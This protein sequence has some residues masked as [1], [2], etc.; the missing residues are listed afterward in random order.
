[1]K[2]RDFLA[3]SVALASAP[4]I[5]PARA[6]NDRIVMACWGGGT[7][8]MWRD[9]FGKPFTAASNIPVTVAE[10]A[11][12]A[13]AIAAAQG[14]PQHNVI[15]AASFQGA[16]LAR[17]GLIE[18]FDPAEL[19][20][21]KH[22]PEQYWIRNSA[23]KI[24]GMPVYFIYYG[25]AYSTARC[26]ASDFESWKSL[27]D[28]RWKGQL[29][30]TRPVFLAPYDLTICSKVMGGTEVNIQPGIPLLRDIA[31]N[32][33]TAYTSMAQLQQQLA[34]GEV[35]AAPFYSSQVQLL[36]RSGETNV[37][38][39]IPGEGG[40]VLSYVLAVPK[41]APNRDAAVRFLN[42]SIAPPKQIEAARNA[43]LPLST[44]VTLPED[45]SKDYGM[46]IEQV[47]GRNWAPDWYAIAGELEERM[48]LVQKIAD[49]AR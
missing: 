15:I 7:A 39:T 3:G 42:D 12:P 28:R 13:A 45:V 47:R 25:V 21:L 36:R 18:E 11:D 35:Q 8:R 10:V 17:R 40:L 27:A 29:S 38:I 46:T 4:L 2:R 5:L 1:M 34:Q 24:L 9:V 43:Y 44:N 30:I 32:A 33:A 14:R 16:S 37:D 20:N 23:G 41:G 48:R 49:E 6:N 22:I 26:K 19:P 31:R